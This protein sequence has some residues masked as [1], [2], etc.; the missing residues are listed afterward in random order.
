MYT[1]Y[2]FIYIIYISI[3]GADFNSFFFFLSYFPYFFL[4]FFLFWGKLLMCFYCW[5]WRDWVIHAHTHTCRCCI[6]SYPSAS[7][8]VQFKNCSIISAM[9]FLW[10]TMVTRLI[11]MIETHSWAT[12]FTRYNNSVNWS[13]EWKVKTRNERGTVLRDWHRVGRKG[14]ICRLSLNAHTQTVIGR[15]PKSRRK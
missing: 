10:K 14:F 4:L 1:V 11:T 7:F 13:K 9:T 6:C 3:Y 8:S 12:V 15:Q 5:T 2:I